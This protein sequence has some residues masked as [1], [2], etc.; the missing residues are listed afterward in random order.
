MRKR[1]FL[2]SSFLATV[3]AAMPAQAANAKPALPA[4]AKRLNVLIIT[5]DDMDISAPGYMGNKHGLTPNLDKLAARSHVFE[6]CRGAAPICMPSREAFMSGLVPH[7]NGPGGFDPM[8]EGT[9]SL[10]S[11]LTKAGWYSAASHKLEHMQPRSSFPWDD[12]LGG[13]D[14]N[15]LSHAAE[16]NR[17]TANAKAKGAPFFINCNI[18][19]PH[20]PFYGSPGGLKKDNNN[21]GPFKIPRE[22]GPDDVD[23]PPFLEDLPDIRREISQYWNS[24]QRMDIAVGEILKA[25]K[26]SGEEANT[27]VLFCNDHGMPF[28]FSK[29][30]GYDHGTRV[31]VILGYPGMGKPQRFKDL[32]CNVDIMPTI[33]E[34]VGMP[35]PKGI[36]GKSWLPRMRGEKVAAPEFIVTYVNGVSNGSL[37]PVRTIQDHRYSLI[38]QIWADSGRKF[39]VDSLTGLTFKA[40]VQAGQS[41]PKIAERARQCAYGVPIS[42]FDR[43]VDPGQRNNLINDPAQQARIAHMRDALL[44]EMVRTKD[45]QLDNVRTMIAGG[46][47]VVVQ[48]GR[49]GAGEGEGAEGAAPSAEAPAAASE[50]APAGRRRRRRR[51]GGG[52]QEE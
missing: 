27:I 49:K 28:P 25:L 12:M 50:P 41:D 15:V 1:E 11:I 40:M 9:P 23:V 17:A 14:R 8:Y 4:G 43:E 16:I 31:P 45:P 38:Y 3:A 2:T 35:V 36:D 34:L 48:T 44:A 47:P 21:Q 37:F 29:A 10:C 42:F 51:R 20:R 24:I 33:L 7:R 19:D 5:C 22:L 18:N 26:A 6:A 39:S 32:C 13:G 46:K 30:S 52:A